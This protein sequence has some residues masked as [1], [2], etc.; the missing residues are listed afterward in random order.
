[1]KV[2]LPVEVFSTSLSSG[3]EAAWLKS[4]LL[5][6]YPQSRITF[7]LEDCDRILRITGKINNEQVRMIALEMG[8]RVRVLPD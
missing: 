8:I 4:A 2:Q 7:D 1:M 3:Q 6:C 5:R